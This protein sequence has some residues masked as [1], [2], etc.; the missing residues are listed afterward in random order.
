MNVFKAIGDYYRRRLFWRVRFAAAYAL[1]LIGGTGA[2]V[3]GSFGMLAMKLSTTES[4]PT[5]PGQ[6]PSSAS[7]ASSCSSACCAAR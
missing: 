1:W 6:S 4:T 2:L 3:G 5:G 7:E